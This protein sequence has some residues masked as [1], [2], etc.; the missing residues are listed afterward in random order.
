M[1][2]SAAQERFEDCLRHW[3]QVDGLAWAAETQ[4]GEDLE[5]F[6]GGTGPPPSPLDVEFAQVLRAAAG[7]GF[8]RLLERIEDGRGRLPLI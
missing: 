5:R 7:A 2:P 4:L 3:R 6:C 1:P 8:G